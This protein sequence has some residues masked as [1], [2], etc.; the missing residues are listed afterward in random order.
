MHFILSNFNYFPLVWSISSSNSLLEEENLQIRALCGF[1]ITVTVVRTKNLKK[2]LEKILLIFATIALWVVENLQ[3][4]ALWFLH[5]DHRNL[6][7]KL[8][9]ISGKT[10]INVRNY[11]TLSTEIFKTLNNIN[12]SFMKDIFRLHITNRPTLEKYKLNLEIPNSNLR[13]LNPK[14][15]NS[16]SYHVKSSENLSEF[17]ALIKSWNGTTCTCKICQI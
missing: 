14:L 10:S 3:K 2:C 4:Q 8:F 7:E 1:N 9:K 5:N 16:F 12:S 17:K 11:R 6:Y 15:W 13:Y